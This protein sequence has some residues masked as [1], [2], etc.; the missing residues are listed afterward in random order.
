MPFLRS[1]LF[2]IAFYIWT[3]MVLLAL[4][5]FAWFIRPHSIRMAA[6]IWAGGVQ[7][8][9]RLIIG[10]DCRVV[11]RE[12]LPEGPVLIA[13]KH[14]SA[15]ETIYFYRISSDIVIGLKYELSRIPLFGQ[16]IQLAGSVVIDRGG[17]AQALRSL[18]RG[19]RAAVAEG[20][21][22]LIFPEGTRQVPGAK[23]DYKSGIA[24]LY[25]TL[26]VPCVPVALNSGL[27][28]GRRSFIKHPGMITLEFLDPI[29]P[30]L[31]RREFM[32][33]LEERIETA[34]NR[35]LADAP[36]PS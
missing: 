20:V 29:E 36:K 32:K 2:N 22:F 8:L 23:P 10:L 11:G 17:A 31:Q 25:N 34:S 1:L 28:W 12:K 15:W 27:Y 3:I 14:Q 35:L 9:L 18:V 13:S 16:Y 19:A 30:G 33:L 6:G 21:S 26:G 24:A 4:V 7:F 5:P